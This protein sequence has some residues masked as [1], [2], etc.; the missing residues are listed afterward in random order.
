MQQRKCL[1]CRKIYI[2]C[3]ATSYVSFVIDIK[4]NVP[5]QDIYKL[6]VN[7]TEN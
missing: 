3:L 1:P 7:T 6:I 5:I 4:I 2:K